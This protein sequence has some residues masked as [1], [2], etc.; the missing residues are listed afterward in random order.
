[1]I[2]SWLF[3]ILNSLDPEIQW[4]LAPNQSIGLLS[5]NYTF[6]IAK[7]NRTS[8]KDLAETLAG[9]LNQKSLDQDLKIIFSAI[10]PYLNLELSNE[11]WQ[12][13]FEVQW[14]PSTLFRDSKTV[15]IDYFSPNVG[16]KMHVGHIRSLD[17][18]ESLRRILKLKFD[19]V[20][21]NNHL[22]D[23]GIQFG[24]IIWGLENLE[25]LQINEKDYP[26]KSDFYYRIYVAV[27]KV[28]DGEIAAAKS[29]LNPE[30]LVDLENK[31]I[32]LTS[33]TRLV[34]QKII[35]ELEIDLK[36]D[37]ASNNILLQRQ[38]IVDSLTNYLENEKYLGLK[39]QQ[40]NFQ[41]LDSRISK[42]STKALLGFYELNKTS[43]FDII[44]GESFYIP[45][46]EEFNKWVEAGI[47]IQDQK[48]IYIDLE[49]EKLGRCYLISSEGYSLYHSRD[50]IA[51]FI[52][53]G[54]LEADIAL[55]CADNRQ[56][57]SF[58]QVFCVLQ[59][60]FASNFYETNDF[61]FFTKTQTQ[62]ALSILKAK[63]PTHVSFGFISLPDGAMSTRKG[64]II[65]FEDLK[66]GLES[67]AKS[68]LETRNIEISDEKIRKICVATL[69]WEDLKRDRNS[70]IIFEMDKFMAFEGNTGVYQ[71][72]TFA[73]LNS[74]L[75]KNDFDQALVEKQINF[76]SLNSTEQNLIKKTYI[77]P[78]I[79]EQISENYKV[80]LLTT[81]LFELCTEINSWYS[82]YQVSSE[83]SL[84]RKQ[85]LLW[86]C[87]QLQKYL[88]DCLNLL[89]I[90]TLEEL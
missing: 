37:H 44:L 22:G 76:E 46:L 78:W 86:L 66:T 73:R 8:P 62:K 25:L 68:A 57:H 12:R 14:Q 28:I 84:E 50:I 53:A 43:N 7:I 2:L 65:A 40:N 52:W 49:A 59:K 24:M 85:N 83:P 48:G 29:L 45:Y 15:L 36:N 42:L 63:L 10:G 34:C 39:E 60:V 72:Y 54:I 30:E 21:S 17:I 35:Q 51:R 89:D 80:H 81:Y 27:N 3:E 16:K 1:M 70:D 67:K 38:I 33:Q 71:L 74:I 6:E 23:W 64:K 88:S 87:Y 82:K 47:A 4:A 56:N 55:S 77:L 18:G 26:S 32:V 69:K 13:Y 20:I 31:R 58:N 41:F 75:K 79:L 9:E 5:T 90:E 61:I 19:R 11:L